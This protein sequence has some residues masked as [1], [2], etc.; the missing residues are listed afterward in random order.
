M[1]IQMFFF[2]ITDVSKAILGA[3]FLKHYGLSVDMKS[4]HLMDPLTHLKVQGISSLVTSS[5]V[6][7][8]L[9]KQP[10][11][12][13]KQ[14]LM[15]FPAITSPYNG[16]VQ[17]MH[18]VTHHI[19][20]KGPPVCTKPR[21][22]GPE[23]LKI[24]KQELQHMLELGIIRPSLS[25]WASPLHMVLKKTAGDWHPCGD[26]HA[27]N[28]STI[29]DR[30]PTP[31]SQNFTAT[32]HGAMIFLKLYLVQVH[33]Y[34]QIPVEPSDM[35]KMAV[36]MPFGL[37]KKAVQT[38]QR[39]MDKVLRGLTFAYNYI[40][41]LL[42][43]SEDFEEDKIHHCMVFECLQDHGI[44]INPS[45]YKLLYSLNQILQLLFISVINFVQLLFESGGYQRVAFI[46]LSKNSL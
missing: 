8:L 46:Q 20:T 33:V 18:D 37:F 1:H 14:I 34:H 29:P 17:I 9:P 31:H 44:L 4:H 28:I 5:L 40:D 25:N 41:D 39:F 23:R 24:T 26:Y 30:Y 22:L 19:G 45:K 15:D 36:I 3:D 13:Y 11:S 21:C 43:I 12:D 42:I 38:F 10:K 7:Q 35:P 2:I 6:L 16:N 27:L 32:L